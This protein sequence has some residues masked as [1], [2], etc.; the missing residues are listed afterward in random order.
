MKVLALLLLAALLTISLSEAGIRKKR[1]FSDVT[2]GIGDV[3]HKVG[4]IFKDDMPGFIEKRSFRKGA[5]DAGKAIN[6]F[7]LGIFRWLK[8]RQLYFHLM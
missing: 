6:R 4:K 1:D 8:V 5:S 3:P 2:Y 7:V